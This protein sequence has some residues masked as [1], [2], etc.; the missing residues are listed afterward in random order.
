MSNREQHRDGDIVPILRDIFCVEDENST[1]SPT[2]EKNVIGVKYD[3]ERRN[4]EE[5]YKIEEMSEEIFEKLEEQIRLKC[6][7]INESTYFMG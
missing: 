3:R 1:E 5:L 4:T 7:E 2:S 6:K